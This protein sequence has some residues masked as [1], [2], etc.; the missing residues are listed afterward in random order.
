[1]KEKLQQLLNGVKTLKQAE[2]ILKNNNIKYCYFDGIGG[3]ELQIKE[4]IKTHRIL[5]NKISLE[6][7]TLVKTH[8]EV[9]PVDLYK[10]KLIQSYK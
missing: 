10:A 5:K 7:K 1:M 6:I 4:G 8:I 9:D 3:L 2:S